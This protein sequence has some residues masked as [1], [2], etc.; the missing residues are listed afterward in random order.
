MKIIFYILTHYYSITMTQKS[1]SKFTFYPKNENRTKLI[2][3][4]LY[5]DYKQVI[6]LVETEKVDLD[7]IADD[8]KATADISNQESV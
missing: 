8:G 3:A 7:C 5:N 2:K 6:Y 4:C 1:N